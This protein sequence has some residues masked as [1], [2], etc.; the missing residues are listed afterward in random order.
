MSEQWTDRVTRI[1]REIRWPEADARSCRES[2]GTAILYVY[3][4]SHAMIDK[5]AADGMTDGELRECLLGKLRSAC[6]ALVELAQ[7]T[8]RDAGLVTNVKVPT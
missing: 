6:D 2:P 8:H 7:R 3:A 5:T 4:T 1:A